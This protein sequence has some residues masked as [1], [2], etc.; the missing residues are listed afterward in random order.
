[1]TD[2]P[3]PRAGVDLLLAVPRPKALRK[4]LPAAA[5]LGVG[6]IVLVNA[7][8]VEKSY[9]DSKVLVP[10][11]VRELLILGLEQARDTRLPEVLVRERFRPFVEDELD[12]LWPAEA[13]LVA[14]PAA[15]ASLPR[16][17]GPAAVVAVG[18]EGGWVAF[19]L[20][21]LRARGFAAFTL[22]P[23]TLRV[24]VAVPYLLGALR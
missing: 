11:A 5:A 17:A 10:D 3:P 19:E 8:R 9:F 6:R 22:G 14:H 24:E 15:S 16:R 12:S 2:A 20:E 21:L 7:A 23:R 4:L 18:P 1:L 13:R